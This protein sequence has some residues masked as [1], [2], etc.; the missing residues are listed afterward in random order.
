[1]LGNGP[2]GVKHPSQLGRDLLQVPIRSGSR[3]RHEQPDA[4]NSSSACLSYVRGALN[5]N[6]AYREHRTPG[7]TRN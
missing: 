3:R 5:R 7:S 1:M 2:A 6:P 4:R